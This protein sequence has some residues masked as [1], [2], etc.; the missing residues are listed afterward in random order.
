MDRL[1]HETGW[2]IPPLVAKALS[3]SRGD[4][5][6]GLEVDAVAK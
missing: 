6:D 3:E 2:Q 5:G 4:G 1:F